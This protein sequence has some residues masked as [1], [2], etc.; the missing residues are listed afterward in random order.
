MSTFIAR[1][2]TVLLLT[3]LLF[4]QNCATPKLTKPIVINKNYTVSDYSN[5]K[6]WA[7]HPDKNDPADK[8]P[9]DSELENEQADTE[10]D[11][12]FL[13]PTSLTKGKEWNGDLN[14]AALNKKTDEGSIQYQASIFNSAGRI[15]APRYRQANL[16]AYY[17][18]DTASA[19]AAFDLAYFDLKTAFEYYLKNWNKGRPIIIAAHSQ[20]TQHAKQ[21]MKEYFDGQ[22]LGNRLVV[23]YLVGMPVTK[24]YF[25]NIPVC[26]TPEQ[27]GCFCS[28]RT[29]KQGYE[30]INRYP[31]SDK[32]AV[33]NPLSWTTDETFV[34][35]SQHKG[36]VLLG[37]KAVREP[38]LGAQVHKGILWVEK[39]TFK[40][41]FLWRTDNYHVGD[42]NLFYF[43]I[44]ED[45]KRRVGLFWK[46]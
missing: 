20:G 5:L 18:K 40:G 26:E 38:S 22:N 6:N 23:A 35:K 43:N 14:D 36:Y 1:F 11:V 33:V 41:S 29:F 32:I 3:T 28:W 39:P 2:S 37:F 31:M 8:I 19:L 44:R 12:F 17:T 27:T 13:H 4:L 24:N 10:V 9:S 15:F 42:Y 7:A 16:Q 30:P 46:R 25:K 21:L 45:A 34:P